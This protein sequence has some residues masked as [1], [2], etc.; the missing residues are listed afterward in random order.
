MIPPSY[1]PLCYEPA[2][3]LDNSFSFSSDP[4]VKKT[5]ADDNPL[6]LQATE[7]LWLFMFSFLLLSTLCLFPLS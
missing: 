4:G 6:L 5:R 7:M 2:D 1:F 3:T